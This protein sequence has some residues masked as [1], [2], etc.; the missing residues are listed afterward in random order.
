MRF[1]GGFSFRGFHFE[2]ALFDFIGTHP[3]LRLT[4]RAHPSLSFPFHFANSD[5]HF[6]SVVALTRVRVWEC[7]PGRPSKSVAFGPLSLW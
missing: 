6:E 1:S 4:A 2:F 3:G 5:D 7:A